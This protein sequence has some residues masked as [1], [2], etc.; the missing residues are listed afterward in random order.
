MEQDNFLAS[1]DGYRREVK[2]SGQTYLHLHCKRCGRDFAK[3]AEVPEWRA[4]HIGI[5][6]F[7][8]LD[9]LTT[10][11]WLSEE[12]TGQPRPAEMNDLRLSS[13]SNGL[14]ERPTLET[15][16]MKSVAVGLKQPSIA[17]RASRA[18]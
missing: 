16:G 3:L 11:R 5:F 2:L 4:V 1:H 13:A 7:D 12:C 8:F 9:E 15:D 18:K 17:A 14:L 10:R 6:R